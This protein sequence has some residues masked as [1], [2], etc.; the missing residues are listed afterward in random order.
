MTGWVANEPIHLN[1]VTYV[2]DML[3][4]SERLIVEIDGRQFHSDRA[5]FEAD[6]RREDELVKAG[7]T[8]LRFTWAMLEDPDWVVETLQSVRARLRRA[9]GLA[10]LSWRRS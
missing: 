5:A 7:W 10:P 9:R 8:V 1:G 6:R 3:F 4:K 2:P